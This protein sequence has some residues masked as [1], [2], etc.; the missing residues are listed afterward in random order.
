MKIK[1]GEERRCTDGLLRAYAEFT[2]GTES[3][4]DFHIWTALSI[5]SASIGRNVYLDRGFYKL[6]PNL[7][8]LLVGESALVRKSTAIG[9]GMG[10]L[11]GAL[12]KDLC[13]LSQKVTPQAMIKFLNEQYEKRKVSNVLISSSEFAVFL[14]DGAKDQ[15]VVQVLTDLYDCPDV[16][17]YTTIGRGTEY[18]NNCYICLLAGSTPDWLKTS[19]PE[20]SIG[21]GFLSRVLMVFREEGGPKNPFPEDSIT[22][23]KRI[24]REN[25][26]NDIAIISG[27][28]GPFQWTPEAKKIFEIWY[29]EYNKPEQAPKNMRGYFGR[30]G[31]IM[32]K[33]AMICSLS[34]EASKKITERDILFAKNILDENEK[35]MEQVVSIMGQSKEGSKIDKVLYL[36]RKRGEAGVDHTTLQRSISHYLNSEELRMAL[37][38]LYQGGMIGK[39]TLGAKYVYFYK[40]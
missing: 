10:L 13:V 19:I 7:Y 29:M 23:A 20:E 15:S 31:D 22:P 9:I 40:G 12:G 26:E 30:K 18:C 34:H 11:R 21:G 8:I 38:T 14:G 3:P 17:S 32:I 1:L 4:G 6:Y 36:I 35:F 25:I 27:I 16:W 2:E 5:L 33:L 24:L 28:R 39:K 37:N